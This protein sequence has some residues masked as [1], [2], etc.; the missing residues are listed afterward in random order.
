MFVLIEFMADWV[1]PS[2]VFAGFD[3]VIWLAIAVVAVLAGWLLLATTLVG[4][5]AG[6]LGWSWVTA[7]AVAGGA[8]ILVA[9][10]AGLVLRQRLAAVSWFADSLNELKNDCTWLKTR[11]TKKRAIG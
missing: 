8:H 5:F 11:T 2:P 10:A 6:S 7:T 4:V 3:L 9:L 1:W